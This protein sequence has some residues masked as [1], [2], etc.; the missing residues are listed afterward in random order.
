LMD[1]SRA[2]GRTTFWVGDGWSGCGCEP[3][4]P[5][6]IC[7]DSRSSRDRC[8]VFALQLVLGGRYRSMVTLPASLRY[9]ALAAQPSREVSINI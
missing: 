3:S 5:R 1:T 4:H 7:L 8:K 6:E 2:P 9:W